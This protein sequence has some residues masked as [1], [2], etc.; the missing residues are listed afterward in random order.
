VGQLT[1]AHTP[2]T[3]LRCPARWHCTQGYTQQYP[4]PRRVGTHFSLHALALA[5]S[6]VSCVNKCAVGLTCHNRLPMPKRL[7]SAAAHLPTCFRALTAALPSAFHT[8]CPT[9]FPHAL[10]RAF[11]PR[12]NAACLALPLHTALHLHC[13]HALYLPH[14]IP[15]IPA[16]CS[17]FITCNAARAARTPAPSHPAHHGAHGQ[18]GV[19]ASGI[20]TCLNMTVLPLW[21]QADR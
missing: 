10:R 17:S 19:S 4:L 9:R 13:P 5:H 21:T 7:P 3:L 20:P 16:T 11:A 15:A 2:A 1:C 18:G 12:I 8:H 6:V 14:R